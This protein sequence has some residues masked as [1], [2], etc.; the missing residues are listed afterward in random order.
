MLLQKKIDIFAE[1]IVFG[2]G[3]RLYVQDSYRDSR[4]RKNDQKED[5]HEISFP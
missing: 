5:S 2:F 1:Q 4:G 3:N